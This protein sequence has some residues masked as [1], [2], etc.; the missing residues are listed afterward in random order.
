MN[1]IEHYR[2]QAPILDADNKFMF[3]SNNKVAQTSINRHLL[4]S[5]AI[6]RKDDPNKYACVFDVTAFD[7]LYKFTIVRNPWD[8]AVSAFF[9]LQALRPGKLSQNIKAM[10]F[11]HFVL[12]VLQKQGVEFNPHFDLQY[13]KAFFDGSCFVD[14]V[15]K[16]ENIKSDWKVIAKAISAPAKLPHKNKKPH[17]DYRTYYGAKTIKAIEEIYARDIELFEYT[18]NGDVV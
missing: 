6:V 5:R 13:P 8:R 16:I 18:F 4:R 11:E 3:F 15:G 12:H 1:I 17:E 14:F 7:S 2:E 10:S 9:Y